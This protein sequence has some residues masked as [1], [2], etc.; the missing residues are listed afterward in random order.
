MNKICIIT[1]TKKDVDFNFTNKIIEKIKNYGFEYI[2]FDSL[3]K[4][5]IDLENIGSCDFAFVLGGDGTV[6]E[7]SKYLSKLKI[8]I[9]SVNLGRV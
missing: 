8:P 2:S 5:K 6:L 3:E 7:T 4:S 9:V 1:N